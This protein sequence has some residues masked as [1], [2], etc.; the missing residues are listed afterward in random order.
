MNKNTLEKILNDC[1]L[2]TDQLNGYDIIVLAHDKFL[3]GWRNGL[4]ENHTQAVLC[5][6]EKDAFV[7]MDNMSKKGSYMNRIRYHYLSDFLKESI[8]S[9]SISFNLFENCPIWNK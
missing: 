7:V 8:K 5:R 6:N 9:K 1:E 2:T 4:P 3:S